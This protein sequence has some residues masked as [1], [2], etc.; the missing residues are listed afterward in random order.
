MAVMTPSRRRPPRCEAGVERGDLGEEVGGRGG[1]LHQRR[2]RREGRE[3]ERQGGRYRCG[4]RR[5]EGEIARF[6]PGW[7]RR[8]IKKTNGRK[9]V[10]RDEDDQT[11]RTTKD[12][13]N[14]L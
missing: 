9:P 3:G 7:F 13:Q 5:E 4:S 6:S 11:E 10:G 12:D 2:R 1:S 14:V 8:Q